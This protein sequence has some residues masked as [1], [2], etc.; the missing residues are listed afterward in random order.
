MERNIVS[1]TRTDIMTKIILHNQAKLTDQL[2]LKNVILLYNQSTL[3]LICDKKLTSKIKKSDKNISA[4]ENGGTLTIKYKSSMPGYN[5]DT[6]YKN[7][8]I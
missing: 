8:E 2:D 6:W 5:Y 4:Q 3:D 7:Y 1:S